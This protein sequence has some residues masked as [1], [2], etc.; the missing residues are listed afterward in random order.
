M[1]PF[2]FYCRRPSVLFS[3]SSAVFPI[4][5]SSV[6]VCRR[7][8]D[9]DAAWS[10]HFYRRKGVMFSDMHVHVLSLE[11][12]I[13]QWTKAIGKVV[14]Y[15]LSIARKIQESGFI[16]KCHCSNKRILGNFRLVWP[17]IMNVGWRE[18]NQQDAT[19]PT[20]LIRLSDLLH[21]VGVLGSSYYIF[22]HVWSIKILCIYKHRYWCSSK[23]MRP[24]NAKWRKVIFSSFGKCKQL[25]LS[26]QC[27]YLWP[28]LIC[29][30]LLGAI[31]I[32]N[33]HHFPVR[34]Y[35]SC[36]TKQV[37]ISSGKNNLRH[38][39]FQRRK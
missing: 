34:K 12:L 19:N 22:F 2:F 13:I 4:L 5:S 6:A 20:Q 31:N 15:G 1:F 18:R 38:I 24:S 27:N 29:A 17:C 39:A 10:L 11:H 35:Q 16:L 26:A 7:P 33:V 28:T 32:Y 37:S 3:L 14:W 30:V 23:Y 21:L 36:D 9:R 25:C 8:E